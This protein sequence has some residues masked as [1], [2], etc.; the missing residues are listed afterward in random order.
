V[1]IEQR[2]RRSALRMRHAVGMGDLLWSV[3][4]IGI[5]VGA[6]WLAFRMEPHYVSKDGR[7]MIVA[8][9][10]ITPQGASLGRWRETK[11]RVTANGVV[12]EQRRMLRRRG[13][14]FRVVSE[15]EAPPRKKAVFVMRNIGE[16]NEV[17][18]DALLTIRLPASSRGVALLREMLP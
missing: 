11:L 10:L 16:P 6:G 14:L 1:I 15:S 8:G 13:S 5:V 7:R 4:T 18:D 9:Q 3:I 2:R 17:T 12:A